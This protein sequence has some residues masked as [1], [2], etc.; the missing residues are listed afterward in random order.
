[1][2]GHAREGM[3]R[4]GGLTGFVSC[5]TKAIKCVLIL[6]LVDGHCNV[7]AHQMMTSRSNRDLWGFSTFK[8]LQQSTL[9]KRPKRLASSFKSQCL[10]YGQCI[11]WHDGNMLQRALIPWLDSCA[12]SIKFDNQ[13]NCVTLWLDFLGW[14]KCWYGS[15]VECIHMHSSGMD[16]WLHRWLQPRSWFQK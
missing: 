15:K 1:M 6:F 12:E 16:L 11:S 3:D 7:W 9:Q 8:L 14:Y 5:I 4:L 2:T 10:D 13:I